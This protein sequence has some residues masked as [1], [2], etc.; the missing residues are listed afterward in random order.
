MTDESITTSFKPEQSTILPYRVR[1]GGSMI[2]AF[3]NYMDAT[4]YAEQ[5]MREFGAVE[6]VFSM[7][8]I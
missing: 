1:E 8:A 7:A 5:F 2:A 4:K 3:D 6:I